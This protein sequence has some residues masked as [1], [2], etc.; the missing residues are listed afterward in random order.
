GSLASWRWTRK[1]IRNPDPSQDRHLPTSA[2]LRLLLDHRQRSSRNPL[3]PSDLLHLLNRKVRRL[4]KHQR[5]S[6][7]RRKNWKKSSSAFRVDKISMLGTN[8]E[9]LCLL[10]VPRTVTR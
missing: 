6:R 1:S 5:S 8:K 9:E 3:I 10:D 4:R 2:R 7:M